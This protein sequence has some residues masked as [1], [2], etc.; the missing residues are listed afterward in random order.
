MV[1]GD[2]I[3]WIFQSSLWTKTRFK[4]LYF[5]SY[6][7]FFSHCVATTIVLLCLGGNL[8][9]DFNVRPTVEKRIYPY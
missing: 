4:T 1:D 5:F 2:N 6:G 3:W 8:G 7:E 9:Q